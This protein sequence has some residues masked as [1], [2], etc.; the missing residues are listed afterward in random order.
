MGP[1]VGEPHA[2]DVLAVQEKRAFRRVVEAQ[3]EAEQGALAGAAR[4][5]EG[6]H[7]ARPDRGRDVAQHDLPVAI[8]EADPVERERARLHG[9]R[10]RVRRIGDRLRRVEDAEDAARSGLEDPHLGDELGQPLEWVPELSD[11]IH[12][13]D[14]RADGHAAGDRVQELVAVDEIAAV[15]E[16]DRGP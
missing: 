12:E 15:A 3:D 2:P 1:Q 14:E 8:A 10:G 9:Q 13:D 16:D 4:A 7:L 6:D 5:D 11:V